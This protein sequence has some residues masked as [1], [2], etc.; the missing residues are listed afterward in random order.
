MALLNLCM[1]FEFFWPKAFFWS[2]MRM[3]I[4]KNIHNLSQGQPNPGFMQE[5]VQKGD[6]LKKELRE[7]KLLFCYRFI[8]I[9]QRP[10]K[11]NWEQVFF[12]LSKTCTSSVRC[13]LC[14][15]YL[16]STFIF[17]KNMMIIFHTPIYVM[18]II[19]FWYY[20]PTLWG[21]HSLEITNSPIPGLEI[22]GITKMLSTSEHLLRHIAT[23]DSIFKMSALIKFLD[24][25]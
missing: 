20:S 12:W 14:S 17:W 25:E 3:A 1:K 19:I 10:G 18:I 15:K 9:S 4:R 21:L 23:E 22:W 13:L 16:D 8:W 24:N 7:L 6:F 2:I 5:K 11:P